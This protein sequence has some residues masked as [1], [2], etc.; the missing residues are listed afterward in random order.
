MSGC[1]TELDNVIESEISTE[2]DFE[3]RKGNLNW[4]LPRVTFLLPDLSFFCYHNW[5]SE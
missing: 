3:Q 5:I 2:N 4:T 1:R